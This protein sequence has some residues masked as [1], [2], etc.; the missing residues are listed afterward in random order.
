MG[1]IDGEMLRSIAEPTKLTF[2]EISQ[3]CEHYFELPG[4]KRNK[5]KPPGVHPRRPPISI[6]F[7]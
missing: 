2:D 7:V 6:C 3:L 1:V 5:P 4:P